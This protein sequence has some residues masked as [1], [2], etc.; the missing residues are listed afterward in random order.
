MVS[1]ALLIMAA[2]AATTWLLMRIMSLLKKRQT[3][4]PSVVVSAE[5]VEAWQAK[6]L[7][8]EMD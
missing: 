2:S 4:Q 5:P 6:Q 1:A 8:L 3:A 7:A